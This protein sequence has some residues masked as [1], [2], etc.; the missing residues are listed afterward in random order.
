VPEGVQDLQFSSSYKFGIAQRLLRKNGFDHVIHA[1]NILDKD[2]KV[3]FVQNDKNGARLGIVT[4]KKK[5]PKAV[6]RNRIKRI[7]REI[8]RQHDIKAHGLDLVVMVRN[9][10]PQIRATPNNISLQ[11]LLSQLEHRCVKQ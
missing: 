2:Y 7:I 5:L 6:D 10:C 8:F 3:Y 11:T 1:E 9:A 4:S